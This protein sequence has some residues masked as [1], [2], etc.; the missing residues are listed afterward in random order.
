MWRIGDNTGLVKEAHNRKDL[1]SA[2]LSH[3]S[4]CNGI[5]HLPRAFEDNGITYIEIY[6]SCLRYRKIH[7]ELQLKMKK[8]VGLDKLEK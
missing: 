3:I 1:G 4:A 6:R 7:E 2:F 8:L 5:V